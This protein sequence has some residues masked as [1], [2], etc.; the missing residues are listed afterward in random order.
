MAKKGKYCQAYPISRL[1]EYSN[2]TENT[3][4]VRKDMQE[5]D[6]K[7]IEVHRELTDSDF[8]YLQEDFVVTDD[9]FI[10]ENIIFADVTPQWIDFCNNT[11]KFEIPV[12]ESAAPQTQ[13]IAEAQ[14]T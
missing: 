6:G 4:N 10:D 11:L 9:I 7:K 14:T 12:Y 3:Q 8:L 2:W 13:E 1:R 5:I